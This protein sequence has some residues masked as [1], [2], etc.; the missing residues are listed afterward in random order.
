VVTVYLSICSVT[1]I[2]KLPNAENDKADHSGGSDQD[3]EMA[4][5]ENA[6]QK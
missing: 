3:Q 2:D 4:D 6:S 1:T 5:E